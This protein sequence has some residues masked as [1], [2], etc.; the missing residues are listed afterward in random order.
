MQ[1]I[2]LL[3]LNDGDK[4]KVDDCFA[5]SPW[6]ERVASGSPEALE[7]LLTEKRDGRTVW[8]THAPA[9]APNMLPYKLDPTPGREGEQRVSAVGAKTRQWSP[10]WIGSMLC[11]CRGR[12]SLHPSVLTM[13]C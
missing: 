7:K 8:K 13:W 1:Q 2:V 4:T 10:R 9:G 6:I 11:S 5:Q 3:L 12:S